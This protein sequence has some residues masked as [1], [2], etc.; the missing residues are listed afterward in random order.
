MAVLL[1]Y[2]VRGDGV[3]L[4]DS[5]ICSPHGDRERKHRD[6]NE[7]FSFHLNYV[8]TF[9]IGVREFYDDVSSTSTP[10]AVRSSDL[11]QRQDYDTDDSGFCDI[12]DTTELLQMSNLHLGD[13][14][15][16][17]NTPSSRHSNTFP[18]PKL[19]LLSHL[20]EYCESEVK[21][22]AVAATTSC[23]T[24]Q[25]TAE[26]VEFVPSE[27]V[28]VRRQRSPDAV[29]ERCSRHR[30][31]LDSFSESRS[32]DRRPIRRS[33]DSFVSTVSTEVVSADLHSILLPP[34]LDNPLQANMS[35]LELNDSLQ[36]NLSPSLVGA[37]HMS[38][39]IA[40]EKKLH[41]TGVLEPSP[42][43]DRVFDPAPITDAI[44]EERL[45]FILSVFA[46]PCLNQL[47]GRKMG[48]DHVDIISELCDR[49]MLMIIRQICGYLSDYDL[50]RSLLC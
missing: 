8:G 50:C 15:H 29:V 35:P 46:P 20:D 26:V 18:L 28:S 30:L 25:K 4:D 40:L 43:E 10:S 11:Q 34:A 44:F 1:E 13:E 37:D 33:S 22:V 48:L 3:N 49:S 36:V 16:C 5:V 14:S 7:L 12:Y 19:C 17:E 31:S 41:D 2:S 32:E 23:E 6:M 38:P 9:D 24:S 21:L 45:Q 47:I 27:R 42:L 39:V